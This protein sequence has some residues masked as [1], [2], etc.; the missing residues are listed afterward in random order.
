MAVFV[1][2]LF[3]HLLGKRASLWLL[4]P[5]LAL[6]VN[7]HGGFL[8]GLGT[9]GLALLLR[10][11]QSL[12]RHGFRV[13]AIL[14]DAVPL[15]LTL[16]AGIA[17]SLLNPLG[18]RLWPYLRT[19][20]GYGENRVYIQE[21]QPIWQV[22]DLWLALV[23]FFILLAILLVAGVA[24]WRKRERIADLP[25]WVWLLSCLPLTLMAFQSNRHIPVQLIWI[26]PVIGLL[27]GPRQTDLA[28]APRAE[29]SLWITGLAG[30]V[31][32]LTVYSVV[33]IPQPRIL[34]GQSAFGPTRPDRAVAFMK[35]NEL[36]GNVYT[37]LWWGSYLTW[38]LYPS[39]LVSID[40][41]N[42]TL[43]ARE[44]VTANFRFY[45]D[46]RPD[47]ET[48]RLDQTDY[49]LVPTDTPGL[50]AIRADSYWTTLYEDRD[51]V[52]F[53]RSDHRELLGRR[54]RGELTAPSEEVAEFF[55]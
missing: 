14:A 13:R 18:W 48:P 46:E 55:Q 19:E 23:P 39:V 44:T 21:W 38:E 25:A 16:A 40:G 3:R 4:P 9:V 54:D 12:N 32:V 53:V 2:V 36:K 31:A 15:T 6:W 27:L 37:P 50:A 10:T 8:A 17:A 34:L 26:A 47:L 52:L 5:L 49:L 11:L 51:A 22:W 42:V 45:S 20:L 43:F 35:V 7:L 29:P 28:S 24:A 41:R 30:I 1:L 33:L